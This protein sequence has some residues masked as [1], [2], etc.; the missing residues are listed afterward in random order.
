MGSVRYIP[1]GGDGFSSPFAAYSVDGH[2]VVGDASGGSATLRVEMDPRFCSLTAFSVLQVQQATPADIGVRMGLNGGSYPGQNNTVVMTNI[3]AVSIVSVSH[4]FVP[5]PVVMP[6]GANDAVIALGAAILNVLADIL[7]F[8][9]MIYLFDIRAR[10]LT[11]M[12]PLL[13]ARGAT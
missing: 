5:V 13:W 4:T 12:G 7:T 10:E 6:G 1:L 2:Q 8:N 3:G 11:P 9:A